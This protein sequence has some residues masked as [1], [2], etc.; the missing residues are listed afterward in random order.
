MRVAKFLVL[1]V[2]L[3][4]VLSAQVA[5][6]VAPVNWVADVRT[7]A[8]ELPRIHPDAFYR[9]ER[10]RWDSA[11]QATERRIGTLTRNQATVALM[12]LVALYKIAASGARMVVAPYMFG[13]RYD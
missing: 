6:P 4:H 1:A 12:E 2:S 3:P 9:L 11:V 8:Q 10:S 13:L 7:I 5:A